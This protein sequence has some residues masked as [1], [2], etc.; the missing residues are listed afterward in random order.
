MGGE[1]AATAI[2]ARHVATPLKAKSFMIEVLP[3]G[4]RSG[5]VLVKT[6]AV[7]RKKEPT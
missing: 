3:V 7:V 1:G 4:V 6:G 2:A 5:V